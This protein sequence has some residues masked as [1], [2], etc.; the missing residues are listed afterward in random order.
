MPSSPPRS[1]P[2][3]PATRSSIPQS[4]ALRCG[5]ACSGRGQ[6]EGGVCSAPVEDPAAA[7]AQGQRLARARGG[8][9]R[10]GHEAAETD[11]LAHRDQTTA[12]ALERALVVLHPAALDAREQARAQALERSVLGGLE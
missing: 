6:T 3:G 12:V 11:A 2:P 4:R 10:E 1:C 9:G 7:L 5:R 8:R